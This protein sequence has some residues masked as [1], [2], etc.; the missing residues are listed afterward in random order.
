MDDAAPVRGGEPPRDAQRD[1][2]NLVERQRTGVQTL[3]KTLSL[4]A[5]R[6][7][8]R[9]AM[10]L[11]D[12]VHRENVRVIEGAGGA[13]LVCKATNTFCIGRETWQQDFDRDVASE[14]LVSGPPDFAKAARTKQL[15][16]RVRAQMIARAEASPVGSDALREAIER[17]LREE[18]S[19]STLG[20]QERHR[21]RSQRIV[22]SARAFDE[23]R[24]RFGRELQRLDEHSIELMPAVGTH[25]CLTF[26]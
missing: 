26:P 6:Y 8:V 1:R 13:C 24:P 20:N 19:R 7:E 15:D 5:L 12:I 25:G 21:F 3:T 14:P 9:N 18:L 16:D 23:W 22:F 2:N 11:A 17:R 4:E 10:M